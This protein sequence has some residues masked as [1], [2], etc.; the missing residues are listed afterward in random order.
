[1]IIAQGKLREEDIP[2]IA[3]EIELC[4]VE[5]IT[6][7]GTHYWV[8]S[9]QR[10]YAARPEHTLPPSLEITTQQEVHIYLYKPGEIPARQFKKKETEET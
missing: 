5:G 7:P 8:E 3:E 9:I 4:T 10:R 1:M 2:Q 6:Y